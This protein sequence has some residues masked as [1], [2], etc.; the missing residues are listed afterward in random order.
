MRRPG[1]RREVT[2]AS[3]V[4][5]GAA[6]GMLCVL[7]LALAAQTGS[8]SLASPSAAEVTVDVVGATR[9][10]EQ[11][12]HQE[13]NAR[14]SPERGEVD[15]DN[16]LS[17]RLLAGT[18][19]LEGDGALFGV[20]IAYER[21]F[22]HGI[23]AVEWAVEAFTTDGDNVLLFEMVLEKPVELTEDLAFYFGGGPTA[24]L[25][26]FE[27]GHVQPGWGGLVL[28]GVEYD[29]GAGFEVFVEMDTA[30]F[31]VLGPVLEADVGTGVMWRF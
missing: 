29:L 3:D 24:L 10:P 8:S 17:A 30:L 14:H 31:Y 4:K 19:E 6:C 1:D 2:L 23:V 16:G 26:A 22:F 5:V 28:A 15:T 18:A 20:G 27:N 21:D 11:A 7:A 9:T 13:L 12:R 25:H